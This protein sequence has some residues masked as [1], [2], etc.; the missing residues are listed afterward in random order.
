MTFLLLLIVQDFS[1]SSQETSPS[2]ITFNNDGTKMYVVGYAGDEVNEY[3][4]STAYDVSTASYVHRY[5]VLTNTQAATGM[6][7]NNDGTKMYIANSYGT[8]DDIDE[9]ILSTAFDVSSASYSQR[10]YVA[11][12]ETSPQGIAFNNDGTKMF[13]VGNGGREVNEYALSSA[14]D[15]TS[16]SYTRVFSVSSEDCTF[17]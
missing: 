5:S 16:A 10:L 8:Y 1:V 9:Y 11:D 14:F 12:R 4:L 2:G 13:V 6:S 3:N 15:V 17:R 7:F